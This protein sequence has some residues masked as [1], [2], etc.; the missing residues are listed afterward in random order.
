[1]KEFLG[2]TSGYVDCHNQNHIFMV[3]PKNVYCLNIE[4]IH[5]VYTSSQCRYSIVMLY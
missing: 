4:F 3:L 5:K 1:M 2:G